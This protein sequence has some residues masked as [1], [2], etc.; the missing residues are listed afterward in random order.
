MAIRTSD[1]SPTIT[2]MIR[3]DHTHLL[4]LF[5]RF[6]PD[7]PSSRK[8]ALVTSACLALELH[9]QLLEEIFY[10][11]LRNVVGTD[12]VLEKSVP[13][14][15]EMRRLIQVLRTS[16]PEA[17]DYDRTFRELMRLTLHHA[18]DEESTLLPQAE[19][20]LRNDLGTLGV[21]MAKRRMQLMGPHAGEFAATTVRSFPVATAALAAGAL[22][23][24]VLL[25]G[26]RPAKHVSS[27]LKH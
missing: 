5:R 7:T 24:G 3:L 26:K 14:H 15:D 10:P 6:H 27:F 17:A 20:L 21:Q 1:F 16:N 12:P 23:L 11:A 8:L 13:E 19:Q 4:A 2:S 18:A 25:F 9:M 22:G